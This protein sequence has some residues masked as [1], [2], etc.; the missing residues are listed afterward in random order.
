[1][2][3]TDQ[4]RLPETDGRALAELVTPFLERRA[5]WVNIIPVIAD[6]VAVPSTPGV[7]AVFSKRGPVV[8]MGTWTAPGASRNGIAP[9]QIGIQHGTGRGARESLAD[10]AWTVP[11]GWR[12][13]SD[14]PRRGVVIEPPPDTPAESVA[15]W[16]LGAL[17]RLCLPPRTGDVDVFVYDP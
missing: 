17:A 5:G 8:P 11:D 7:F 16:L 2:S 6:D 10:V 9:A 13:L 1:M 12:V 4:T 15:A 3:P 14:H